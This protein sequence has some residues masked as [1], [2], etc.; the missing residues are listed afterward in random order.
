MREKGSQ[1]EGKECKAEGQQGEEGEVR[2]DN[3]EWR[4]LK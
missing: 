2:G 4:I 3:T 1:D